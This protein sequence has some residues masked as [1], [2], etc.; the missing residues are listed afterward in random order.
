M[1]MRK[2][3][4]DEIRIGEIEIQIGNKRKIYQKYLTKKE[5][6]KAKDK[7]ARRIVRKSITRRK[8]VKGARKVGKLLTIYVKIIRQT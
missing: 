5:E 7:D 1:S 2:T 4:R 8:N 3:S 6:Y